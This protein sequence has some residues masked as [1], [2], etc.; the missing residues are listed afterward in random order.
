MLFQLDCSGIVITYLRSKWS[1]HDNEIFILNVFYKFLSVDCSI[2]RPRYFY[3][4]FIQQTCWEYWINP[5]LY[6]YVCVC[7]CVCVCVHNRTQKLNYRKFYRQSAKTNF[8]FEFNRADIH[9][10]LAVLS[11]KISK[12]FLYYCTRKI[13]LYLRS[14]KKKNC[15]I[16]TRNVNEI[17]WMCSEAVRGKW[18]WFQ[19]RELCLRQFNVC[20]VLKS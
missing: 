10:K 9:F 12:F 4:R 17:P 15:Y 19:R 6:I 2:N 7:V 1:P 18:K 5:T 13:N 3:L 14:K 8:L 16:V 20:H 11:M